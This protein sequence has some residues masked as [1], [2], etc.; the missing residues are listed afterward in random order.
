[1][2]DTQGNIKTLAKLFP[3]IL[4]MLQNFVL[5]TKTRLYKYIEKFTTKKMK[6][7]R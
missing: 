7:F 3:E 1:M 5:I 2:Y 6:I 4:K